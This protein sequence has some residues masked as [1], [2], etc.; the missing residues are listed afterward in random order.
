MPLKRCQSGGKSGWKW[1]DA[2]KCY[3]GEGAR[4]K[5]ARQGAAIESSKKKF[6]HGGKVCRGM[7]KAERGGRYS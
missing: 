6:A 7:G 5:A 4:E 1:G 3:T 2:G